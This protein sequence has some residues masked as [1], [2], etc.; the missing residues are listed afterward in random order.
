LGKIKFIQTA[1]ARTQDPH[2]MKNYVKQITRWNR[3]TLQLFVRNKMWRRFSRVNSFI[4]YQISQN[5]MFGSMYLIMLPILSILVGSMYLI[6]FT[7]IIDVLTILAFSMYA[8][9]RTRRYETMTSFPLTYL[10]RW[11]QL[12]VFF[13]CFIEVVVLRKFRISHGSWETVVRR[14]QYS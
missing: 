11:V 13:K 9:M 3:G 6:A 2:D 5:L 8:A 1:I 7:F 4:T 14:E 12:L 10:L